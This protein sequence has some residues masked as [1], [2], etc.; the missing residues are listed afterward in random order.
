MTQLVKVVYKSHTVAEFYICI[1]SAFAQG[2]RH[3]AS[4]VRAGTRPVPTIALLHFLSHDILIRMSGS[5]HS[6]AGH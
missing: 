3:H 1:S 5:I 4:H 6:E 2:H